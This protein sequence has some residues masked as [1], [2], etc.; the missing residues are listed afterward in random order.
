MT[1]LKIIADLV[2]LDAPQYILEDILNWFCA[3]LRGNK[4]RIAHYMDDIKGEGTYLENKTRMYFFQILAEVVKRLRVCKWTPTIKYLLRNTLEWKFM[5]RDHQNLLE[6]GL[7]KVLHTG[8]GSKDNLLRRFWGKNLQLGTKQHLDEQSTSRDV[9]EYFENLLVSIIARIVDPSSLE[10]EPSAKKKKNQ[11]SL[12]KAK[13][14]INEDVSETLLVQGFDI[15]FKEL[16]RYVKIMNN[17]FRGIDWSTYVK[18]RTAE[19]ASKSLNRDYLQDRL[20]DEE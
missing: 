14:V 20:L 3:A 6:L 19:D 10:P 12:R 1:G 17:L 13:S 5:G 18:S 9:I 2:Q 8:D 4:N 7:L 15:I 16:N 11:L